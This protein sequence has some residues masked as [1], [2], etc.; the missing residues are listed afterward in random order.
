[1][2]GADAP[3]ECWAVI[4]PGQRGLSR[5]AAE[6]AAG[7]GD[8]V[9]HLVAFEVLEERRSQLVERYES[10]LHGHDTGSSSIALFTYMTLG[11]RGGEAPYDADDLGR[12]VRLLDCFPEWRERMP[13]MANVSEEW[14]ELVPHWADL[15]AAFL[16]ETRT[17]FHAP[18]T[19]EMLCKI[20][21]Q[22]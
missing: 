17:G 3:F 6:A 2:S 8:R 12:C 16:R 18:Q 15:E 20:R 4:R 10:W 1:M 13:E 21:S 7:E 22:T 9:V 11:V 19:Y 5:A 14:A